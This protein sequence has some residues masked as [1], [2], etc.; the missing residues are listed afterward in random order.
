MLLI[1]PYLEQQ[2]IHDQWDFRT[3]VVGNALVAQTDIAPFYC[4]TRRT[5]IRSEDRAHLPA[6]AWKGGGNDYGGCIGSG[7]GWTNNSYRYFT[8][9]ESGNAPE[10]WQYWSRQGIFQP[11]RS[12]RF[13][14]LRDGANSTIMIGELQRLVSPPS[15]ISSVEGWAAGGVATLFTT[16][17]R[18]KNGIYQTGGMNNRFFESPGSEHPGGASFGMADG[19]VHFLSDKIDSQDNKSLF[20]LLGSMADGQPAQTPF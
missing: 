17:N 7:N 3:N 20:P 10:H 14:D 18:E 8:E 1:L 19:S 4:P 6:S 2:N 16:N 11:N 5:G 15:G 13:A 12:T 9:P